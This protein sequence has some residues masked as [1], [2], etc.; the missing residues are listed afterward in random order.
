M[1]R[2]CVACSASPLTALIKRVKADLQASLLSFP[3]PRFRISLSNSQLYYP[4][5]LSISTV[6]IDYSNACILHLA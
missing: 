5:Y 2:V 1:P 3:P 4:P 6:P